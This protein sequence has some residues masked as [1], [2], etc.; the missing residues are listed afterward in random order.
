MDTQ[1]SCKEKRVL[2][3]AY[4]NATEIYSR[5]VAHLT[6]GVGALYGEYE[7]LDGKVKSARIASLEAREHLTRHVTQHHC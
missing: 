5:T 3:L 1:I 6:K 2:M 4:Q 7:L